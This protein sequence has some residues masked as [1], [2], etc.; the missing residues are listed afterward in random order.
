MF[1][2]L[3]AICAMKTWRAFF[4]QAACIANRP[5]DDDIDLP[6]KTMAFHSSVR[7]ADTKGK[8]RINVNDHRVQQACRK[9]DLTNM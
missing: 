7:I 1:S 8:S 2:L 3:A 6:L 9:L 5:S 4:N